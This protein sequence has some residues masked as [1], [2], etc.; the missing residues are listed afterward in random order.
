L[1][2]L[3]HRF[4]R[5]VNVRFAARS[6]QTANLQRFWAQHSNE[7][8][9]AGL[10]VG[11]ALLAESRYVRKETKGVSTS[12][13]VRKEEPSTEYT[14]VQFG[15]LACKAE[16]KM[17]QKLT[18]GACVTTTA[19]DRGVDFQVHTQLT[20]NGDGTFKVQSCTAAN[21]ECG[22]HSTLY[23]P[24]QCVGGTYGT[25]SLSYMLVP[26]AVEGC[27]TENFDVAGG[28]HQDSY[29]SALANPTSSN[30]ANADD[31]EGV[32]EDDAATAL[33]SHTTALHQKA[34]S[35]AG[36]FSQWDKEPFAQGMVHVDQ[37]TAT[38]DWGQEYGHETNTTEAEPA[39][40]FAAVVVLGIFVC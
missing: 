33:V 22:D 25:T 15:G 28:R 39:K 38:A 23:T 30:K 3:F 1:Q 34:T 37:Q 20:D 21:C 8:M 11:L 31:M 36:F 24:S 27:V 26:G 13:V 6:E 32:Y 9:V 7:A 16:R 18:A 17:C 29:N 4:A 12:S 5:K 2:V 10:F 19:Q 35:M 14:L 40:S